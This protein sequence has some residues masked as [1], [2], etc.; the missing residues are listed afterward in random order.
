MNADEFVIG[1]EEQP[2]PSVALAILVLAEQVERVANTLL[3]IAGPPRVP[4]SPV[5]PPRVHQPPRMD[6]GR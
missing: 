2:E 4:A 3:L 6:D 5:P 1:D